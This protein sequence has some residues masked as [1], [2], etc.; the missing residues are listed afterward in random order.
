[1]GEAT[2]SRCSARVTVGCFAGWSGNPRKTRPE[3]PSSGA[4]AIAFEVILP[5]MDLP[6]AMSRSPAAASCA[7]DTA[8]RT[9]A[10]RT[11]GGSGRLPP[12]ST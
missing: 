9:V 5:P 10:S 12:A 8:A 3:T 7:V 2:A 4:R 1:M 11:A 6:P